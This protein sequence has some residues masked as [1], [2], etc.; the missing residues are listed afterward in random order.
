MEYPASKKKT[1]KKKK[2]KTINQL[3]TAAHY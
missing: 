3:T 1:K 2:K